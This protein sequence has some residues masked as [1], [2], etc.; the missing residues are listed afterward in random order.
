M[1]PGQYSKI[2]VQ[3]PAW[4]FFHIPTDQGTAKTTVIVI[5]EGPPASRSL[6]HTRRVF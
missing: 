5:D 2:A 3:N 6:E 1:V 4:D